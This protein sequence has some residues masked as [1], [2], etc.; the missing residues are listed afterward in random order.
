M[1]RSFGGIMAKILRWAGNLFAALLLII[2]VAALAIWALS[3][4]TLGE[5]PEAKPERLIPASQASLETGQYLLVARACAECH[6][7]QVR[8]A[9]FLDI[10]N[11][12]T[13][14]APNL[15]LL[16]KTATDQQLAQ[17]IR[18]GIGH[19]GRPLLIMPSESYQ[20]FTDAETAALIK[21]I[22]ALPPTGAATPPARIGPRGRVGI[23]IGKLEPGPALVAEYADS[24][25]ADL[26]APFA[27]GRHIAMT[28]CSGCHG[29]TFA[30]KEAEPGVLAPDLKIAGAYDLPA[31]TRLMRTGLPPS[32][33]E[34]KMMS[35]VS[36][37]AFSHMT[38]AEIAQLH[39][40]LKERANRAP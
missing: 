15:P 29:S 1:I 20:F 7:D 33:R 14:Y 4:R 19:D 23:V 3:Q 26:G 36:R 27:A 28:V 11:V 24:Q 21:A 10:P 32:G 38:D 16:A 39:A 13:L 34:L 40:Y 17:S 31:F 22:R 2:I 8:G 35:G 37:K 30:G 25:P 6:G 9:K 18:Q 12:A 5:R